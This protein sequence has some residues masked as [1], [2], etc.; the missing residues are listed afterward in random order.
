MTKN[1]FDSPSRSASG[2]GALLGTALKSHE[3]GR[4][5]E[6]ITGYK[7]VL[8]LAPRNFD[9][10]HLLGV[11]TAQS[12][13]APEAIKLLREALRINPGSVSGRINLANTLLE[14]KNFKDAA[15]VF[16]NL[17]SSAPPNEAAARGLAQCFNE[18]AR[19]GDAMSLVR[20]A[21]EKFPRSAGLY[22]ELGR[23]HIALGN[24]K[25]AAEA[26]RK[27]VRLDP[28]FDLA[29]CN[30]GN[31]LTELKAFDEAEKVLR[32]VLKARPDHQLALTNLAHVYRTNWQAG[33]AIEVARQ[34]LKSAPG[35]A[36][37]RAFIGGCLIDLGR[38]EEAE[39][40]F[41]ELMR[42]TEKIQEAAIGLAQIHKFKAG[43]PEIVVVDRLL[44]DPALL[45][46]ERKPLLFTKAKIADDLGHPGAAVEAAVAAKAIDPFPG[47]LA[48][49]RTYM[50][51]CTA[52][53]DERF[54]R[55][56]KAP[57]NPTEQPVFILGMPRSGTT[58]TEQIIASHPQADGAGE[59][60]A[61]P[62]IAEDLGFRRTNPESL[63]AKLSSLPSEE[64][65]ALGGRYLA[66]LQGDRKAGAIRITDKLPHNFENIWLIAL[67]FPNARIIH[68]NRNAVDVCVSI[69]LRNFSAGHW[70]S[71]DLETLG[72]YY[73]LY[74]E[75]VAHWKSVC[76][77]QW[78]ENDYE[79]LVAEPEP[80]I[81]AMIDFLGLPW[82]DR[83]LSHTETERTVHTFSKWQV[84]QPI[85]RSSV[86]RWRK[87]APYIGPLLKELGISAP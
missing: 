34:A 26:Y 7:N 71:Q 78:Y 20:M 67:L 50:L 47:T 81:R 12:G 16:Q 43:D 69:F 76:G 57:A 8:R 62:A 29:A 45:P 35:N 84:R 64:L 11:A 1:R 75:T 85:Y 87:Y 49:Y 3:A 55:E 28:A 24:A 31:A 53:M 6:A 18:L 2:T 4:L 40:L 51:K 48:D 13:N 27:A 73:C 14:Q 77:L 72:K 82:D 74:K 10:L 23:A 46:K 38:N 33:K 66:V 44:A 56:R 86:E 63:I 60:T 36:G 9:A 65:N 58:L 68:C 5:A 59:L 54:F 41:R 42:G 39:E 15:A 21:L 79:A 80:N 19:P 30:L 17:L 32:S 25:E 22:N 70:Y 61:L 52:L 83:C 37:L